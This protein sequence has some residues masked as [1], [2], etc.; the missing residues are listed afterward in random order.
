MK[1]WYL[2]LLCFLTVVFCSAA[3]YL[4]PKAFPI[5]HIPLTT[6]RAQI[7]VLAHEQAVHLKYDPVI[8]NSFFH[9]ITFQSDTTTQTF[10]ELEG[11][12]KDAFKDMLNFHHYEPYYWQVRFFAPHEI[13][14]IV[15]YFTPNGTLYGF[16]E[17][18][19]ENF[20]TSNISSTDALAVASTYASQLNI[21]LKKYT[22]IESSQ[23]EKPS[24]RTDHSFVYERKDIH[25]NEGKYR[26]LITVSG[27]KITELKHFVK[28]PETFQRRYLELRSYNNNLSL[29]GFLL[30]ALLYVLCICC[31]ALSFYTK[32]R[33]FLWKPA[34]LCAGFITL[35]NIMQQINQL[36]L[37]MMH[38]ETITGLGTFITRQILLICFNSLVSFIFF[39]LIIVVA[40]GLTRKAFPGHPQLWLLW[41]QGCANS[42]P[43]I[44]QTLAGYVLASFDLLLVIVTY[45]FTTYYFGWWNPSYALVDPNILATYIPSVNSIALSLQAGFIEECLFRAIPLACAVLLGKYCDKKRLFIVIAFVIQAF[46]FGAAHANYPAQPFYARLFELIIPSIIWG[47]FYIRFGLLPIIICHVLYDTIWFSLPIFISFSAGIWLQKSIIILFISS[48]L[49]TIAYHYYKTKK[50]YVHIPLFLNGTWKEPLLEKEPIKQAEIH[51]IPYTKQTKTVNVFLLATACLLITLL[52]IK[53]PDYTLVNLPTKNEITTLA[54]D[55]IESLDKKDWNYIQSANAV[56]FI[57]YGH[58]ETQF[59][60]KFIWQMERAAFNAMVDKEYILLPGWAV[61]YAHFDGDIANRAEEARVLINRNKNIVLT[62]HILPENKEGKTLTEKEALALASKVI[63]KEHGINESDLVVKSIIP[64]KKEHRTDWSI[65]YKVESDSILKTGEARIQV[66]ITGSTIGLI[67]KYIHVPEQWQ[68]ELKNDAYYLGIIKNISLLILF[69]CMIAIIML[70][71][72]TVSLPHISYNNS[73]LLSILII[74]LNGLHFLN[75]LPLIISSFNTIEPWFLQ[76]GRVIGFW[77][78]GNSIVIGICVLVTN[79]LYIKLPTAYNEPLST[80]IWYTGFIKGSIASLSILLCITESLS[81]IKGISLP[82]FY[83]HSILFANSHSASAY[84]IYSCL[85]NFLKCL[86]VG[87]LY[88]YLLRTF[89]LIKKYYIMLLCTTMFGLPLYIGPESIT[90]VGYVFL[91]LFSAIVFIILAYLIN[92]TKNMFHGD[93]RADIGFI[94][95]IYTAYIINQHCIQ[96]V[97]TDEL[98]GCIMSIVLIIILSIC[99]CKKID[100]LNLQSTQLP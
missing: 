27:D 20:F 6:N 38:Y 96:M 98:I 84:I 42:T 86:G 17:T 15:F 81:L 32:I 11:G 47:I 23:Q 95:G 24:G 70:L 18:V 54:N 57:S 100:R 52:T 89:S 10:V 4:F 30:M 93:K 45:L 49:L 92:H 46:I 79:A 21:D 29:L 9:A 28:I 35:L 68:R 13:N 5:V 65:E 75:T 51:Y 7:L 58:P 66:I 97:N 77:F 25:L 63:Y 40:E 48:P 83:E 16:K 37:L 50:W 59:N 19:S 82:H 91:M 2:G 94:T 74:I 43:I 62:Q 39:S 33:L 87:L 60:C 44:L 88:M 22:H 80:C 72:T 76:M 1:K 26:L 90:S 53:N 71:L 99:M 67:Q 61:R 31:I 55:H 41:K 12:G 69:C 64:S 36:P 78:L 14:E 85:L 34:L 8:K 73:F 3:W 56:P